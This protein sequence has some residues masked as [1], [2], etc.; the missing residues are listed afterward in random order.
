MH[1]NHKVLIFKKIYDEKKMKEYYKKAIKAA[2]DKI[3]YNKIICNMVS[4]KINKNGVK[5][6]KIL[7]EINESENKYIIEILNIFNE[8]YDAYKDNN[9][10]TL[11]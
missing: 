6:L 3:N 2:E 8:M 5:K 1:E 7:Q 4:K 10:F 9:N 11:I